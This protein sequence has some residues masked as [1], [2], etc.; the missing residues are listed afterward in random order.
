MRRWIAFSAPLAL[1]AA[2]FALPFADPCAVDAQRTP[3]VRTE[4]GG[5]RLRVVTHVRTGI[6]PKSVEVT[7]DGRHVWVA[8]FGR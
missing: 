5:P 8:N 7:P 6:Q 4:R 1:L 3:V 2:A